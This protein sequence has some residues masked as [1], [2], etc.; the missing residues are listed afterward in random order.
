MYAYDLILFS[1][2]DDTELTI[3][4]G[5]GGQSLKSIR[6]NRKWMLRH[7]PLVLV[8]TCSLLFL[9]FSALLLIS[10]S[11]D[12]DDWIPL[13]HLILILVT[14]L[15]NSFD[16]KSLCSK[17]LFLLPFSGLAQTQVFTLKLTHL[18]MVIKL[19]EILL[20]NRGSLLT[21]PFVF[22]TTYLR[23]HKCL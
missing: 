16:N 6:F 3:F 10:D 14:I 12:E 15:W 11:A 21:Y 9:T 13:K 22:K 19:L 4:S 5:T 20:P 17:Q 7:L 18:S 2:V 8:G 1:N 23:L